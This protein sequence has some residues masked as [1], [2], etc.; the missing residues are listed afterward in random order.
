M[1]SSF[2]QRGIVR[3]ESVSNNFLHWEY[4]KLLQALLVGLLV[5]VLEV[6]CMECVMVKLP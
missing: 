4:F 2:V 5:N 6:C 1:Y 3:V